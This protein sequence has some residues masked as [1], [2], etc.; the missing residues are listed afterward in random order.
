MSQSPSPSGKPREKPS[1]PQPDQNQTQHPEFLLPFQ[2]PTCGSHRWPL[3]AHPGSSAFLPATVRLQVPSLE[4]TCG[5]STTTGL[6]GSRA[7]RHHKYTSLYIHEVGKRYVPS[8]PWVYIHFPMWTRLCAFSAQ[9]SM[10]TRRVHP[11]T[12]PVF[13]PC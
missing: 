8:F 12:N 5:A 2:V 13:S 9:T 7:K 11:P 4:P 1:H 10:C 6:L 3:S